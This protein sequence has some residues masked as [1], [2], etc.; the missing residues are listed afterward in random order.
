ML[1]RFSRSLRLRT[2]Y[3]T[4]DYLAA[5]ARHTDMRVADDPQAAIGGMWEE[6][7]RL[8]FDFLVGQGMHPE[9]RMLDVGCG[10]LRG[11]R[12]CIRYLDPQHYTGVDISAGALEAGHRL[13]IREGLTAKHPRLLQTVDMRFREFEGETFDFILAQSVFSHLPEEHIDECFA[14]IGRVMHD[15]STFY[16]TFK[17]NARPERLGLKG[18]AYPYRFFADLASR[19]GYGLVDLAASYPH[20]RGQQMAALRLHQ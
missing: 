4:R 1:A 7:G 17:P 8:Q 16:F 13:V 3:A 11:G 15:G 5:Y 9:H 18:F 10:T 6:I 2:L 19:H 12:H 14:H 20:P